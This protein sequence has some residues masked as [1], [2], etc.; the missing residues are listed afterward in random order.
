MQ[1]KREAQLALFKYADAPPTHA[2]HRRV[3]WRAGTGKHADGYAHFRLSKRV[4]GMN[5]EFRVPAQ[6]AGG[7]TKSATRI[8]RICYVRAALL[9]KKGTL[10]RQYLMRFC[11]RWLAK[12]CAKRQSKV[13]ESNLFAR[14]SLK[15]TQDLSTAKVK[16]NGKRKKAVDAIDAIDAIDVPEGHPAHK[17]VKWG[18]GKGGKAYFT[19]KDTQGSGP[20]HLEV[21]KQATGGSAEQAARIARLCFAHGTSKLAKHKHLAR[22]LQ[23]HRNQLLERLPYQGYL[24]Q[25]CGSATKHEA[26]WWSGQPA[27]MPT[28][29][30][31]LSVAKTEYPVGAKPPPDKLR[32]LKGLMNARQQVATNRRRGLCGA[33]VYDG[34]P[35]EF[36]AYLRRKICPNVHRRED[37][38]TRELHR[39]ALAHARFALCKD[40]AERVHLQS[41]LVMN[42]GV[43]RFV[44]GTAA[45]ARELG[46][47]TNWGEQ[48]RNQIRQIVLRAYKHNRVEDIFSDA[49]EGPC[50]LR[51]QLLIPNEAYLESVLYN[52]GPKARGKEPFVT[53]FSLFGKFRVLDELWALAPEVVAAAAIPDPSSNKTVSRPAA[54]VLGRL[55]L[56]GR[57]EDLNAKGE[58]GRVPTFFAK[59]VLQDLLD[60]PV[61]EGGRDQVADLRSFCPAGPGALDG[62]CQLYGLAERPLQRDA[63][64]MMRAILH[65][66]SQKGSWTHGDPNSLELHDVQFMLCELQ[67]FLADATKNNRDYPGARTVPHIGSLWSSWVSLVEEALVL[68]KV[69]PSFDG[70]CSKMSARESSDDPCSQLAFWVA[71]W[72]S[73]PGRETHKSCTQ[74][75]SGD[76]IFISCVPARNRP[77]VKL[78]LDQKHR[79]RPCMSRENCAQ[80]TVFILERASGS[81]AICYGDAVYLRSP[82]GAHLGPV[83][84][85]SVQVLGSPS[86]SERYDLGRRLTLHVVEGESNCKMGDLIHIGDPVRL[87]WHNDGKHSMVMDNVNGEIHLKTY[88]PAARPA[89]YELLELDGEPA[90]VADKIHQAVKQAV[91]E[92]L[93]QKRL[94][95]TARG[96]LEVV[97]HEEVRRRLIGIQTSM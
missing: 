89:Q 67:K 55:P 79:L 14:V 92:G 73:L 16:Q 93:Q 27:S 10:D 69:Q 12:V 47:L 60:T 52:T 36:A 4:D 1:I 91:Q 51:R 43:W 32:I 41:L 71:D 44:G 54:T 66:L 38:T 25:R 40:D 61:F 31:N 85:V 81:G 30:L 75:C 49:Y 76:R 8:A 11:E 28:C 5:F 15:K 2:A 24:V 19:L 23:T 29:D 97:N 70:K 78:G 59:E 88:V 34:L 87:H 46:F 95:E 42:F 17:R 65:A 48:Q 64:P 72:L 13:F 50:K 58:T 56:F 74:L 83:N 18:T 39:L 77:K 57:T 6:A 84:S 80:P 20:V 33:S 22:K 62:L 53:Y 37:R 96:A 7:C 35:H 3:S 45:F 90:R 82:A 21:T 86:S 63:I 94:R 9:A 26:P 68:Q